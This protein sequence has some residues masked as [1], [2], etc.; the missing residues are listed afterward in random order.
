VNAPPTTH[1]VVTPQV[2][3]A[4]ITLVVG[5]VVAFGLVPEATGSKVL[6][7]TPIIVGAAFAAVAAAHSVVAIFSAR[8]VTPTASPRALVTAADG[9]QA[10]EPLVPLSL[11]TVVAPDDTGIADPADDYRDLAVP[12]QAPTG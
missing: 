8:K 2:V 11:A 5:Q 7:A 1:P 12:A 9:T 4:A 10:L 6:S 3:V